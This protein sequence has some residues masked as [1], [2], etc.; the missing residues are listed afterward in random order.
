MSSKAIT[1]SREGFLD[2]SSPLPAYQQIANDLIQRIIQK[3]WQ[4]EDKLPSE[5]ELAA[6]YGVSRVT[7]RQALSNLEKDHIIKKFQGKGA[8]VKNNPRQLVNDLVFPSLDVTGS[9]V[10]P[11]RSKVLSISRA[12]PPNHFVQEGLKV[13]MEESLTYV[14]QPYL[15]QGERCAGVGGRQADGRQR[16]KDIEIFVSS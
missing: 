12:L 14:G 1:G 11:V 13:G 10:N 2:R 15:V 6:E 9:Y 4:M 7:L 8:Y 3:E 16:I 5:T